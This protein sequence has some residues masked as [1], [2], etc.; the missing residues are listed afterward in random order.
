MRQT[1]PRQEF[2][3]P[4]IKDRPD[5]DYVPA[6]AR[7]P[8]RIELFSSKPPGSVIAIQQRVGVDAMLAT[9]E[10]LWAAKQYGVEDIRAV[11]DVIAITSLGT[12][13]HAFGEP[14][15][16]SLAYRRIKIPKVIDPEKRERLT[17]P[18]LVGSIQTGLANAAKLAIAIEDATLERRDSTTNSDK[19]GRTLATVGFQ[20]AALHDGIDHQYGS[21]V[22]VQHASWLS[23]RAASRRALDLSD[24]IGT[25]PTVAAL[26]DEQSPLRRYMN[27]NP[28]FV[29]SPSYGVLVEEINE[30]MRATYRRDDDSK[31]LFS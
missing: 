15:A 10:R 14:E 29:P 13:Y 26:P 4:T 1:R 5:L 27:D 2:Q 31:M 18:R 9:V 8:E 24:T 20:A 23:A 30:A 6:R 21:L 16:D 22:D 11:S 17:A 12:A 3:F 28:W 19:L 25:R 7:D